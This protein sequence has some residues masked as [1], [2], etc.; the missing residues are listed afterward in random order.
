MAQSHR[1]GESSW[2]C[3]KGAGGLEEPGAGE[4]L[5]WWDQPGILGT[6]LK[7]MN[8]LGCRFWCF[9]SSFLMLGPFLLR[10]FSRPDVLAAVRAVPPALVGRALAQREG[11]GALQTLVVCIS[12]VPF[13]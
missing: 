13:Q 3:S 8:L 6:C 4:V 10:M 1:G 11:N 12:S 2:W 7:N 5:W 9:P